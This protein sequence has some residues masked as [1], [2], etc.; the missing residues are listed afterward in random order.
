MS[1]QFAAATLKATQRTVL[2]AASIVAA[3]GMLISAAPN[4]AL[5]QGL[6]TR[7]LQPA[8]IV[9]LQPAQPATTYTLNFTE[10]I[11]LR[12]GSHFIVPFSSQVASD[13]PYVVM[14]VGN[15]R[16]PS[17][18]RTFVSQVFGD[19][20]TGERRLQTIPLFSGALANPDDLVVLVQVVEHD[21]SDVTR[22]ADNL[23]ISLNRRIGQSVGERRSELVAALKQDMTAIVS[24]NA[25]SYRTDFVTPDDL[26]GS[27]L[28]LRITT[29]HMAVAGGFSPALLALDHF[30]DGNGDYRTRFQLRKS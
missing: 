5:A 18:G 22:I 14:Y 12:E 20:D 21:Q 27:T 4:A 6:T 29:T 25:D 24:A 8:T 16:H 2:R 15:L 30:G 17:L 26:V 23:A 19:M 3:V 10:L 7:V 9:Q 1:L 28:E 13:E 11:C